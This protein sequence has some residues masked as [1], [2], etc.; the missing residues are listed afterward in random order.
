MTAL[1][2]EDDGST[3]VGNRVVTTV[4][5]DRAVLLLH[6]SSYTMLHVSMVS[7]GLR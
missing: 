4:V 5:R 3:A 7:Y 6:V 2:E 1:S